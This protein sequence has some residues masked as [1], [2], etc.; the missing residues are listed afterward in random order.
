MVSSWLGNK[1]FLIFPGSVCCS[2]QRFWFACS[3]NS[4]QQIKK[5]KKTTTTTT[6][7]K[8]PAPSLG[9]RLQ[10]W[11]QP[12]KLVNQHL[13]HALVL[14]RTICYQQSFGSRLARTSICP[15]CKL[16]TNARFLF[17][18][19]RGKHSRIVQN[20]LQFFFF[21]FSSFPQLRG[22]DTVTCSPSACEHSSLLFCLFFFKQLC[23]QTP[24][25]STQVGDMLVQRLAPPICY[26]RLSLT[27]FMQRLAPTGHIHSPF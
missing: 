18:G 25:L 7:E 5:R 26:L 20:F 16:R 9:L 27:W 10:V 4:N 17:F 11:S 23:I 2:Y 21:F 3:L 6:K 12:S 1:N 8:N 19:G 22:D 24:F 14:K 15:F 13:W